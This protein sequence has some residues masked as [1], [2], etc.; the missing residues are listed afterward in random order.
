[1]MVSKMLA[2]ISRINVRGSRIDVSSGFIRLVAVI[3]AM[4][5]IADV[6]MRQPMSSNESKLLRCFQKIVT[7]PQMMYAPNPRVMPD[8][9]M[10]RDASCC[11]AGAFGVIT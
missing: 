6:V 5:K 7:R 2:K 11:V 10:R 9:A 8:W 3:Y 1:L 4:S